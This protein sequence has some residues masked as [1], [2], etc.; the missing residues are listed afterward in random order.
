MMLECKLPN[1]V[2]KYEVIGEGYPILVIHGFSCDH[3]YIQ[4]DL[5]P[6]FQNR[7]GWQRIY[8]DLPGHGQTAWSDWITS[9]NHILDLLCEFI[10]KIF[11]G[12]RFALVGESWGGMFSLGIIHR[13]AEMI[14]GLYLSVPYI[15][16]ERGNELLP[17]HEIIVENKDFAAMLQ[18]DKPEWITDYLVTQD[19]SFIP[20]LRDDIIAPAIAHE[21]HGVD[22][23]KIF[24]TLSI[25]VK[26]ASLEKPA[27]FLTG[28]QDQVVGYRHAFDLLGSFPRATFAVLDR[29]GHYMSLEQHDLMHA[30]VS[31]WLGRV[32]EARAFDT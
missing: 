32:E 14:D 31:E 19:P 2:I 13:Q 25:D 12:E 26:E 15:N 3:Q 8:I 7:E 21:K 9:E 16:V 5:E 23:E 28:K 18:A 6:V 24:Y 30:L 1:A 11:L 20:R 22:W 29:A 17:E 27:L 4:N 10:D